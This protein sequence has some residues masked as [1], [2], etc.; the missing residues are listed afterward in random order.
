MLL[1]EAESSEVVIIYIDKGYILL[2]KRNIFSHV[3]VTLYE[4]LSVHGWSVTADFMQKC[5]LTSIN[6]PAQRK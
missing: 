4:G 2:F 6:T 3:R 1:T 5:D